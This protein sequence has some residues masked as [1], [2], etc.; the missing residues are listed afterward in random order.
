MILNEPGVM[1]GSHYYF[2]TPSETI[3][4]LYY[5]L[6]CCGHYYCNADYKI[7]RDYFPYFLLVYIRNGELHVNYRDKSVTARKGDILLLNCHEPHH[8]YGSDGLEFL[9]IHFDGPNSHELCTYIIKQHGFH[10]QNKH[11]IEIGKQLYQLIYTQ[12]M[13]QDMSISESTCMIYNMIN[14]LSIKQEKQQN[15]TSPV[16]Q[17]IQFIKSNIDRQIT[18]KEIASHVNLSPFYF[19]HIFKAETGYAP[20]EFSTKNR[21]D[22]AKHLLKTTSLSIADIAFHVGYS[23]SSGFINIFYKKVGFTPTEFRNLTI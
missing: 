20:I 2:F 12:Y 16:D 6:I 10:F 19:S 11:N 9:Y 8:Y 13:E 14:G 23:S 7:K 15:E 22:T 17:A 5:H 4:K 3:K 18:L 1:N 21:I